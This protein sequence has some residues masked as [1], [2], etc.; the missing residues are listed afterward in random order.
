MYQTLCGAKSR[1]INGYR[2]SILTFL[3]FLFAALLGLSLTA[4]T[5]CGDDDT[6]DPPV[7]QPPTLEIL[8]PTDGE[9]YLFGDTITLDASATDPEDGLW[10]AA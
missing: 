4:F 3:C 8:A 2:S 6:T 1:N 9:V 7:N 5:A 10:A